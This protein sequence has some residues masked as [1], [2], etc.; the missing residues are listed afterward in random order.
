MSD[1]F[2]V[3]RAFVFDGEPVRG[4]WVRLKTSYQANLEHQDYPKRVQQLLGEAL[5]ATVLLGN[6]VKLKGLL[7]LQVQGPGPMNLLVVQLTDRFSF[8]GVVRL[9]A[10]LPPHLHTTETLPT[11]VRLDA[12]AGAGTLFVTMDQGQ[13]EQRYQGVVSLEAG[14]L[15]QCL[16]DYFA[17][18]EQLPT[19][20]WLYCDGESVAGLMLQ[21]LPEADA[22]TGHAAALFAELC[23]LAETVSANELFGLSCEQVLHRLFHEHALRLF[24]PRAVY[25]QCGCSKERV[26]GILKSLGSVEVE[27]ILKEQ[28]QV[29]IRCEFCN[30]LYRYDPIDALKVLKPDSV[31]GSVKWH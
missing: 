8:R 3:V 23:V 27:S 24:E 9:K 21:Q 15:T 4:A 22:S 5:G 11:P 1:G 16:E 7:T 2:E 31:T 25:F 30:R 10:R 20:L 26:N 13:E 12:L 28:G 19:R 18:S 29:E 17:R 6:S 14:S